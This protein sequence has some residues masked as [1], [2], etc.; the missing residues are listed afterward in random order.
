[1]RMI[2]RG[3]T[4]ETCQKRVNLLK[5]DGWT[6]ITDINMDPSPTIDCSWVCVLE[7]EGELKNEKKH[8]W[9]RNYL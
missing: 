3:N 7:R 9:N 2:A 5:K 1:M 6:Q 8:Q 4:P